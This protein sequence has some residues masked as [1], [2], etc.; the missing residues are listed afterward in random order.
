MYQ[1]K[2]RLNAQSV[3]SEYTEHLFLLLSLRKGK[4][5]KY[6]QNGIMIVQTNAL[7][8]TQANST[9]FQALLILGKYQNN[10]SS[11]F[12]QSRPL[13]PSFVNS[14]H[15]ELNLHFIYK[16]FVRDTPLLS[17]NKKVIM[18]PTQGLQQM[19]RERPGCLSLHNIKLLYL[20][21]I[22]FK[23]VYPYYFSNKYYNHAKNCEIFPQN[24]SLQ[25]FDRILNASLLI[26]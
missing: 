3:S 13:T 21:L 7:L 4:T 18:P 24:V 9:T 19:N 20:R 11:K 22:K 2:Q 23:V 26:N 8:I 25:M 6:R 10:I 15:Q 16:S 1:T 17:S 12:Y 14:C 5:T